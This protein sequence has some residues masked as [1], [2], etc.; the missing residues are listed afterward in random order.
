MPW[1]PLALEAG[2]LLGLGTTDQPALAAAAAGTEVL[3]DTSPTSRP[4]VAALLASRE[5]RVR[6]RDVRESHRGL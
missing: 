5:R 2:P 3:T 4:P 6:P 1:R